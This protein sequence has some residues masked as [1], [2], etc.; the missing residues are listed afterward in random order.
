MIRILLGVFLLIGLAIASPYD[1]PH[2]IPN[3]TVI[4]HLFEW[5]WTDIA[6]ECETFLS[7]YE[8]GAVQ[9][10]PP[11]EHIVFYSNNDHPWYTR[12]QPV[13]YTLVSRSG[14]KAELQDMISRCN[15]VGVRI[16]ADVVLNHM[17]GMNQVNDEHSIFLKT[18]CRSM[19]EM[20]LVHLEEQ[21]LMQ[22]T[23]L[24]NSQECHMAL[25][26]L[27]DGGV[28]VSSNMN[29]QDSLSRR[30]SRLRLSV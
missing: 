5:K 9:I 3:R 7:K 11:L 21:H 22:T 25:V 13:S 24:S 27:M 28:I 26:I 2:T 4:V 23:T 30:H 15:K 20:G 16:I 19:E 12:Y 14:D 18:N 10:S 6:I 8:Y 17:T 29:L 1:E